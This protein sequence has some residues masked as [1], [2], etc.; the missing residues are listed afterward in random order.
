MV[1]KIENTSATLVDPSGGSLVADCY[2][3]TISDDRG[4]VGRIDLFDRSK[5]VAAREAIAWA[6]TEGAWTRL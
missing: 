2:T 5:A 3:I 4:P 1:G 6:V